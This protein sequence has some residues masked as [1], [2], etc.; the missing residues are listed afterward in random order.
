MSDE[1]AQTIVDQ[2]LKTGSV[3]QRN[4][5]TVVVGIAGSGKTSLISRLFREKPPDRY[6]STGVAEQSLRGLKHNIANKKSWERLSLEEMFKVFAS[7]IQAGLPEADIASLAKIF[8]EEEE[9]EP[10]QDPS[11]KEL[12]PPHPSTPEPEPSGTPFSPSPSQK[13]YASETMIGFVQTVPGSKKAAVIELLHMIDTGGQPEF[14]EIM[15]SLIHNSNLILLVL[16]LD[17]PLDEEVQFV[18]YENG[19]PFKR[20]LPSIRTNRQVIHQLARTLQAKRPVHKGS[21][22]SKVSVIGTHKDCVEK[23]GKLPETLEAMNEEVERIFIEDEL[24]NAI[25]PVNLKE[26]DD[27]DEKVLE[28]LRQCITNAD[29]GVK[30]KIPFSFFLFEHEAIKYAEQKKDRKVMILSFEE[31]VQVGARLKMSRE[32]VKAALIF[33]H[34][35]NI[36]L[37][38]QH[39]LPNVV[40]LAPQVPLD[41][42]NVIVALAYKVRSV[43][44]STL[45]PKYKRFCKEGIITG[46]MLCDQS[47]WLSDKSLQLSDHFIPDIYEPQD[48]I[49]L[50]LHIYAIAPL[51]NE[52]AL[53][54]NQ[55]PHTSSSMPG[56]KSLEE[57]EYLMMTLLEDKPKKDIQEHLPSPSKV[58][59]LVIHFSGGCV[60]NGCF[61]NTISCLISTYNWEVCRTKKVA[62]CL[63][64]NIVTL[65]DPKLPV[66]ITIVNYTQH[67]EIHVD[68]Y[69]VE[70][71]DLGGF[72]SR[73]CKTIFEAIKE[74]VFKLMRFEETVVKPAFLFP[75]DCDPSHVATICGDSDIV[76]KNSYIVC[77]KT[78]HRSQGRLQEQHLLWFQDQ[79]ENLEQKPITLSEVYEG[80][81]GISHKWQDVG[82]QLKLEE[83]ILKAIESDHPKNSRDCLREML[84]AWLKIDL[85]P[86]WHTLCA[87]LRSETVGEEKVASNLVAKYVKRK[88][89]CI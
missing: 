5:V 86:T 79:V 51:R 4:T 21:Q 84:S 23:K 89:N 68:T 54:K 12:S 25:V 24:M 56:Q 59:P 78:A 13:C 32:V 63:A 44:I 60:P 72:C 1:E 50:F 57:S 49:N 88:H 39:I 74:K 80:L 81:V 62:K 48:V 26:P 31:C 28:E 35:H 40:F 47:L 85:R 36:F 65:S 76:C 14:M 42:I 87:A 17:Q 45:A 10:T 15:P 66:T 9:S 41:F 34:R 52:E 67:L 70:K 55:Q 33:F 29:I 11:E 61:G 75:C 69:N 83:G 37:Y 30:A 64:H 46:E 73:I 2:A 19:T 8:T 82:I 38:F 53:A 71:E 6:T 3:E 27:K 22:Y 18:F 58:A 7:F 16:N 77:S 43:P 20:P